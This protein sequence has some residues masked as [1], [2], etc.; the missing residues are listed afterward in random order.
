[1]KCGTQMAMKGASAN[2]PPRGG[3]HHRAVLL[4]VL[5]KAQQE[6]PWLACTNR[7]HSQKAWR[8]CSMRSA[9]HPRNNSLISYLRATWCS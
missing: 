8:T 7:D 5:C 1:M 3:T 6:C 9:C 4:S 2:G